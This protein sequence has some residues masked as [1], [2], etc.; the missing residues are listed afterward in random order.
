MKIPGIPVGQ[1]P[2]EGKIEVKIQGL[3]GIFGILG[4]T[5]E[6]P[7]LGGKPIPEDVQHIMSRV[8]V[9]DNHGHVK[10]RGQIKLGDEKLNLGVLIPKFPV[11]IKADLPHRHDPGELNALF[12]D[13]SP[14]FA[15][16]LHLRGRNPHGMVDIGCGF[17]VFIDLYKIMET[18][19]YGNES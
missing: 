1:I 14:V 10:F 9:M 18:V 19:A 7:S 4:V 15:G 6:Y 3:P 12:N 13:L 2:R 5:V 16:I 17:E 11:V 8:P